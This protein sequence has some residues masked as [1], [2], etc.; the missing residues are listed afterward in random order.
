MCVY[1]YAYIHIYYR[2]TCIYTHI[3]S[4]CIASE[5]I[6]FINKI[7][8]YL[9]IKQKKRSGEKENCTQH[10]WY[11]AIHFPFNKRKKERKDISKNVRWTRG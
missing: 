1:T 5:N 6:I 10:V 8:K 7:I 3:L 11:E 4:F 2:C 9:K